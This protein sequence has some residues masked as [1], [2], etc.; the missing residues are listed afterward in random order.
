MSFT[1]VDWA[2][3]AAYFALTTLIGFMF[4]KRGGESLQEYFISGRN[5][6]W[7]VAGGWIVGTTLA[8][9]TPRAGNGIVA[10]K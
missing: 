6:P 8:A 4:T 10:A 5:V 3:V 9:G 7:W 2:V 1:L